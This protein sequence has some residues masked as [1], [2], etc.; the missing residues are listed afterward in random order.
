MNDRIQII[1]NGQNQVVDARTALS[2]L[3]QDLKIDSRYIAISLNEEVIPRS[4]INDKM[5][6]NGD[7][8][9]IIRAVAGG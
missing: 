8:I 3:L 4:Q 7:R 9:E 6:Q 2:A 1:I 5:I